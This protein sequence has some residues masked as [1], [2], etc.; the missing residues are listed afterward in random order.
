MAKGKAAWSAA[1]QSRVTDVEGLRVHDL[2]AGTGRP[3]VFVHGFA[4]SSRYFIP[5]VLALAPWFA[6]RAVDLPGYGRSDDPGSVLDINGLAD[7]LA[8]WLDAAGLRGAVLVGNSA[9]CQIV[10]DCAARYPELVGPLVLIGPTVDPA[11]RSAV[12][13]LLRFARTGLR[14]DVTQT[15][16]LISDAARAGWRRV[17]R[18]FGYML[19]DHIELKLPVITQPTL[20]IRGSRDPIAPQRWVEQAAAL[21]PAGRWETIDGG[22]HIVHYTLPQSVG[23]VIRNSLHDIG[24]PA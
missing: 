20:V 3:M 21:L 15:P 24:W 19:A 10:V 17:A 13:Q 11:A 7:A 9:G 5:T 4:I 14:S 12:R 6:C 8:G 1:L 23:L 22:A 2:G 18:T 16:L